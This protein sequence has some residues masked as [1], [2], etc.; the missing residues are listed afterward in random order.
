MINN[1]WPFIDSVSPTT[2]D[3][4]V[5]WPKI[6]IVTPSYNQGQFIEETILSIL[7]QNYPNLEYIIIDGGSTDDTV[8][9]LKK[10]EHKLTFWV[11]ERDRGQSHAINKGFEKATGE[12][13]AYLNSDDCYYPLAL[14]EIANSFVKSKGDKTLLIGNCYWANSF[15]DE[16]GWLDKPNFPKSLYD[17][18][19][20][21]GLAP[22]PSM[23]WTNP[24]KLPFNEALSFC[25]D[26]EFWLKLIINHYN[27]I[28]IDK[29][30]SLFRVHSESKTS[31]LHR[32]QEEELNGVSLIYK[33]HLSLNE[34][35]KITEFLAKQTQ[36]DV[37]IRT[38]M[39]K[40][41][42]KWSI[43]KLL[44]MVYYSSLSL[45]LK[46]RLLLTI[47]D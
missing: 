47:V 21:R 3:C 13:F 31:T 40:K 39:L 12:I 33:K 8:N 26:F 11:S 7:N 19:K 36:L 41:E 32:I 16:K 25:M 15:D 38:L 42:G 1:N 35:Q 20:Q 4:L 27:V 17:A 34:N 28:C 44:K 24:Q 37:Y 6:S 22:Q 29:T 46:I 5:N 14:F 30:L 2:Y 45:K 18:L 9:I 23:F 10:Y 43:L